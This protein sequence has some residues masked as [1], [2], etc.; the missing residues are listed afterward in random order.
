MFCNI[1]VPDQAH[2][3]DTTQTSQQVVHEL[4]APASPSNL[5]IQSTIAPSTLTNGHFERNLP[6]DKT[7]LLTGRRNT[8]ARPPHPFPKEYP[9]LTSSPPIPLPTFMSLTNLGQNSYG[10]IGDTILFNNTENSGTPC[11]FLKI[12]GALESAYPKNQALSAKAAS[13]FFVCRMLSTQKR[14]ISTPAAQ[15]R[16]EIAWLYEHERILRITI[17]WSIASGRRNRTA[18]AKGTKFY[19]PAR[20]IFPL[21]PGP[22]P[23]GKKTILPDEH[24]W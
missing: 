9:A 10:K 24:S 11:I 17:P 20:P 1:L 6:C 21:A 19:P 13:A 7:L 22:L 2:H 15:N 5:P 14:Q 18:P 12:V 23:A 8:Q 16:H 4:M 3:V